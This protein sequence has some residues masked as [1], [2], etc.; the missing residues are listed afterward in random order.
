MHKS[1]VL[2]LLLFPLV[3]IG[4]HTISFHEADSLSCQYYLQGEWKKLTDLTTE[5]FTKEID[6][7]TMRQRAGYAYFM[8]GDYSS[9]TIQY[10]KALGYDLADPISQEYLYYSALN[11]GSDN[12]R[13]YAGYLS[14][15][16]AARIG[17]SPTNPI[18]FIDTEFNLKT[19]QVESRSDQIYY[20]FG[21]HSDLGYHLSLY[22]AFSYFTQT[23]DNELTTQPEYFALVKWSLSPRWQVKAAYHHL[24]TQIANVS[25]P[26]NLGFFA[27]AS[28]RNR[29]NFE[30]NASVL[31][32]SL[33]TTSQLGLQAKFVV[34]GSANLYLTG[35]LAEMIES[36]SSRT[37]YSQTAGLKCS[38]N[39]WA[40]GNITFGNLKNYHTYQSLYVY[41]SADPTLFRTGLSLFYLLGKHLTLIGNFTFNQ[42]EIQST[43][44][45]GNYYQYSY[46]GGLKWRL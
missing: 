14:N 10:E 43:T 2:L 44:L 5:A 25:Y 24:F 35:S 18:G 19:N 37:I 26:G 36:G 29:F 4:Q 20:R 11:G 12:T 1:L 46:S 41:N 28:Q 15:E 39:L 6:S 23:L 22:Q 33:A 21:I 30:A 13:F 34:P 7:K 40:E 32:T 3:T 31:N 8:Q 17:V 45:T 38:K 27:I 42:Q 16:V 9:A